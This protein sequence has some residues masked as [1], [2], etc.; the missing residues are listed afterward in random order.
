[1]NPEQLRTWFRGLQPRERVLV[2]SAGALIAIAVLYLGVFGPFA[3]AVATREAR[4]NTKQQDLVWMRSVANSV[5]IASATQPGGNNG[6]SLVVLINR[7]AQQSG[8]ASALVNQ[9]PA[10]DNSIR[11]RLERANFDSLVS[12]LG[13]LQQQY[14]IRVD[15]ASI[16][17]GEKTGIVNASLVLARGG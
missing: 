8:L 16:D 1:M 10:G 12:W 6:E 17:R 4:V 9:A 5:R 11:V 3:K 2:I 13:N 15:N 7:T 14:S